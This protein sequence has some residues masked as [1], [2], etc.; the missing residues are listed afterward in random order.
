MDTQPTVFPADMQRVVVTLSE[1]DV[2]IEP[3]SVAQLVVTMTNQQSTPDRL[4]LEVE[5][6]DVE[7]YMIPVAAVNVAPG[8]QASERIVFKIARN[9][10]NRAGTYPFLVRVQAM[11]TGEV[12]V[13]QATLVVKPFSSLQVELTPKRGVATFFHALNDFELQISNLGNAEETLELYADD[14]DD[15]CAYEFDMER[16]TLKPGQNA[17]VPLAMRP[18]ATSVLG[19]GRLIG[20]SVTARS[21]LNAYVSAKAHGQLE[22]RALISPFTGIFLLLFLLGGMAVWM[23]WPRPPVPVVIENFTVSQQ[24]VDAGKPITISWDVSGKFE[25]ITIKRKVGKNNPEN[26]P[27]EQNKGSGSVTDY[28]EAPQTTYQIHVWGEG[29]QKPKPKEVTVVVNPPPPAPKPVIEY[30]TAT[31]DKIHQGESLMLTWK[32]KGAK[33]LILDPGSQKLSY[34]EQSRPI[35]MLDQDTT[36]TLR[37]LSEDP[38][39]KPAEK[40]VS[41]KVVSPAV[42]IAE[43][44]SFKVASSPV[45]I[46]ESFRLKWSTKYARAVR[47]ESDRFP[48]HETASPRAGSR[49]FTIEE[50]TTFKIIATDTLGKT[51]EKEISVTPKPR[52]VAPEPQPEEDITPPLSDGN[53]T[54]PPPGATLP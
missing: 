14:P 45:Y 29:K 43:I 3:G 44:T 38:K 1:Y 53:K 33:E 12:G 18:K 20:F 47:I 41:V 31:P 27:G 28:P 40:T 42:C 46:G 17:A 51:V 13:A 7:W 4:T 30:F 8:A 34:F 22:K 2:F 23:N 50:P 32:T 52:P 11:E 6:V 35:S 19:G 36:F 48:P 15:E 24:R 21:A 16:V 54:N 9:S 37:A 5:G 26:N 25:R 49:D 10:E 39:M